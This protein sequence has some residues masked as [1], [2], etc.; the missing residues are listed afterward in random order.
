MSIQT[1]SYT[2]KT[3]GVTVVNEWKL[4]SGPNEVVVKAVSPAEQTDARYGLDGR[5]KEYH[6]RKGAEEVR[7]AL[8]DAGRIHVWKQCAGRKEEKEH[9]LDKDH[10]W[11]QQSTLGMR[12]FILDKTQKVFRF[13]SVWPKNLSLVEMVI[14]KLGEEEV[15]GHG[16][17]VKVEGTAGHWLLSHI[18][19]GIMWYDPE[20]GLLKKMVDS[21]AFTETTVTEFLQTGPLP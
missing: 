21:G 4:E 10:V 9:R 16:K 15:P 20:T 19:K 13:Y 3:G 18:R 12:S 8:S 17:L 11:V 7:I 6:W 14:R 5:L 1:L 2:E